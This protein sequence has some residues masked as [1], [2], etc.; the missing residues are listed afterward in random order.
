MK[1]IFIEKST[2]IH[3]ALDFMAKM[4]EKSLVVLDKNKIFLGILSDGDI[5][6]SILKGVNLNSDVSEIYNK[7]SF[8]LNENSFNSSDVKN[9]FLEK[10]FNIIPVLNPKKKVVD[11]LFWEIE[12][13]NQTNLKKKTKVVIMAGGKGK[14]LEPFSYILPKPLIP[15]HEKPI[16]SHIINSFT[17]EFF[18]DFTITL[19]YKKN[20]IQSFLKDTYKKKIS[21]NFID[22]LEPGGTAG[23]LRYLKKLN[24]TKP[25]FITNCDILVKSNYDEIYNWHLKNNNNLTIVTSLMN[26]KIPYGIC[27]INKNGNLKKID[28]KPTLNY[29]INTG[30]YIMS[31]ICLKLIPKKG[32]YDMTNLIEACFKK[33]LKVSVYP[34]AEKHWIDIGQ[35][36]EYKKSLEKFDF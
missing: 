36:S 32:F 34:I 7:K 16:I 3:K 29:L 6:K 23:S 5:R 21:L 13:N 24:L 27:K 17:K 4:G 11:I 30:F 18:F 9:I 25:F 26:Y 31:P 10:R 22:E 1:Q 12:L 8:F 33:K 15:V 19:N 2:S 28:E 20:I 35:W 14:R